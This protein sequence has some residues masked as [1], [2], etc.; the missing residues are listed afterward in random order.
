MPGAHQKPATAARMYDYYLGGIHNF[1]ADQEAAKVVLS[2]SPLLPAIARSNRAFLGRAVNYLTSAGVRQFLD[3]GSGIPTE[4]NVHEIAQAA[5]PN[6]RVVYVDIDPEAV[7]ESLDLLEGNEFATAIRA[8]VREPQAILTHSQVRKLLDFDQPVAVLLVAVL[9]FVE[10]TDEA[11]DIVAT[12]RSKLAPGSHVVIAHAT[13]DEIVFDEEHA[14]YWKRSQEVYRR[15]TTTPLTP[16]TKSDVARLFDGLEMVEPGL[17]WVN[18][19][20]P[21]PDTADDFKDNPHLSSFYVGMGR[22]L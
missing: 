6:A 10:D 1:P 8:D 19:W 9:H 18:Q 3:L 2:K 14:Q 11:R 5:I 7:S 21:D 13:V 12:L 16:R 17:T 15:Q 22:V 4:G 20:R